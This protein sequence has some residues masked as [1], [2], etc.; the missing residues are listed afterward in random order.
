MTMEQAPVILSRRTLFVENLREGFKTDA[1]VLQKAGAASPGS[2]T[3]IAEYRV[4]V[5]QVAIWGQIQDG[6]RGPEGKPF[7]LAMVA[8]QDDGTVIEGELEFWRTN[9]DN[10][11]PVRDFACHT[12]DLRDP[13]K[14]ANATNPAAMC[15]V[16]SN[17]FFRHKPA[18]GSTQGGLLYVTLDPIKDYTVDTGAGKSGVYMKFPITIAASG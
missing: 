5:G 3:R 7:H 12:S 18:D 9:S 16:E 6:P 17:D 2:P 13:A 4:E 10:T 8:D 1:Q 14:A 11:N 15:N